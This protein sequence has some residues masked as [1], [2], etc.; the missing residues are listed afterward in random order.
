MRYL[1]DR[2]LPLSRYVPGFG[3][4]PQIPKPVA[5]RID[6]LHPERN[7]TLCFAVDL[8]NH[9]FFWESHV[10]LEALWEAHERQGAVADL[11]KALI[12]LA[13]VE[14]CVLQN[15]EVRSSLHAAKAEALFQK[16]EMKE[17]AVFLGFEFAI[18]KKRVFPLQPNWKD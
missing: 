3:A 8:L 7:Q 17:G 9:G 13:A 2:E 6:F 15:Q 5:E 16:L 18:L 11:M 4:H 10:Y 14:L 12:R 1:P